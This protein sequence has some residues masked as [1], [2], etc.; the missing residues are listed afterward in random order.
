MEIK[1]GGDSNYLIEDLAPL[2]LLLVVAMIA[3]AALYV[4]D[5]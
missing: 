3:A 1:G 2:W 4:Y 5:S